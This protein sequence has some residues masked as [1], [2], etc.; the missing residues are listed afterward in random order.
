MKALV[1]KVTVNEGRSFKRDPKGQDYSI[2]S[3]TILV[4]FEPRTWDNQNGTGSS[5]GFGLDSTEIE[6]DPNALSQFGKLTFPV[7]LELETRTDYRRSGAVSVVTG[8]K[9]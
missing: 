5:R 9:Q 8:F 1:Q 3:L 4:P 7:M 2:S 6:L